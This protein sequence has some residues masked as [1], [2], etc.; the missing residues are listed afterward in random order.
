MPV[1]PIAGYNANY[2]SSQ[3][4][5][6]PAP[7]NGSNTAGSGHAAERLSMKIKTSH[8]RSI[9]LGSVLNVLDPASHSGDW[10]PCCP[11]Q[12]VKRLLFVSQEARDKPALLGHGP[13]S[14]LLGAV[15][16]VSA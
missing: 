13:T 5:L 16:K 2:P 1:N 4:L 14:D 12:E 9:A 8:S 3:A 6:T 10:R 15:V 7:R 11:V